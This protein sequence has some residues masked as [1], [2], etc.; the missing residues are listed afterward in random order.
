MRLCL[1]ECVSNCGC[2]VHVYSLFFLFFLF[3]F[4]IW[5]CETVLWGV[6]VKACLHALS[7]CAC[8]QICDCAAIYDLLGIANIKW[9]NSFA[10]KDADEVDL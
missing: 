9:V 1:G 3:F 5:L 10:S 2:S 7:C 8:V 6:E 4:F